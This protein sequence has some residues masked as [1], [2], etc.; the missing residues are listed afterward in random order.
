[1]ITSSIAERS[2]PSATR[3]R[4][5]TWRS[6][7]SGWAVT[8]NVELYTGVDTRLDAPLILPPVPDLAELAGGRVL[9]ADDVADTGLTLGLV[10][11]F[12]LSVE[13]RAARRRG[14]RERDRRL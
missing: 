4:I 1:M 2:Y 6:R 5:W 12:C 3:S 8:L 14:S 9:I 11:D 7:A 10:R 13:R